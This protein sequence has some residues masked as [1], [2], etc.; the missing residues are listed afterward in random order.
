M[1]VKTEAADPVCLLKEGAEC[2][3]LTGGLVGSAAGNRLIEQ[4]GIA[5]I[6]EQ[7]RR[8]PLPLR[9]GTGYGTALH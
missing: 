3:L 8:L 9:W 7:Q 4:Q 5:G 6:C 1:S 2:V